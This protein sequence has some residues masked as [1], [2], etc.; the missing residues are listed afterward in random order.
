MFHLFA[1]LLPLYCGSS[2]WH[3]V[4]RIYLNL[5]CLY[6]P[7]RCLC[8]FVAAAQSKKCDFNL[9]TFTQSLSMNNFADI[10]WLNV[11]RFEVITMLLCAV[12]VCLWV[13]SC[14]PAVRTDLHATR[15]HCDS[16]SGHFAAQRTERSTEHHPSKTDTETTEK[17]GTQTN[18]Y[19]LTYIL[20]ILISVMIKKLKF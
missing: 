19:T 13:G 4:S 15:V 16:G 9:S 6:Y 11:H 17:A 7:L 20:Y 8:F 5:F 2:F 10:Y 3:I 1:S 12:C 14:E 18:V